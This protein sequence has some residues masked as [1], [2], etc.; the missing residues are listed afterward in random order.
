MWILKVSEVQNICTI[1]IDFNNPLKACFSNKNYLI[2]IQKHPT[3]IV[4]ITFL[5]ADL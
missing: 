1:P 4:I 2:K 3:Q 5:N